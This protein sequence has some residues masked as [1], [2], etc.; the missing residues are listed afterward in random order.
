MSRHY[1]RFAPL[2]CFG[3]IALAGCRETISPPTDPESGSRPLFAQGDGDVWTV[4]TLDD[5]G[6]GTCDDAHCTL[7]EAIAA[8]TRDI[9]QTG[10]TS[11]YDRLRAEVP[12]GLTTLLNLSNFGP[13]KI[14]L[15]W[16]ELGVTTLEELEQAAQAQRLPFAGREGGALVE[17]W[18]VQQVHAATLRQG[19]RVSELRCGH[20]VAVDLAKGGGTW[21]RAYRAEGPDPRRHRPK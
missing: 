2:F 14:Q 17:T 19:Q 3:L 6:D 5:P 4:N 15:V 8:K 10:T 21:R 20:W 7:R 1:R 18:V 13:K 12:E 16:R 9:L 11:L